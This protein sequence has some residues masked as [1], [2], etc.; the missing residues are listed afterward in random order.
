MDKLAQAIATLKAESKRLGQE[1]RQI[2]AG[3]TAL[4]A[5]WAKWRRAKRKRAVLSCY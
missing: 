5:R 4:E 3:I 2:Q 1:L